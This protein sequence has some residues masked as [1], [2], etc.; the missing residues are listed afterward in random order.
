MQPAQLDLERLAKSDANRLILRLKGKLSLETVHNFIQT[1]RPE[2]VAH[3]VLDLSEV[4]FLDSAGVGALVQ[5]FVHRRNKGQSFA[6]TGLSKQSNAV[7]QV[8]GLTKLLPIHA[9]VEE[10]LAQRPS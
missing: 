2:P 5:V 9:S 8:A 7:M 4:S 1:V 6:L 10:A 3:L